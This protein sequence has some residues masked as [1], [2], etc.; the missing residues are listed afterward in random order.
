VQGAY[1]LLCSFIL[2]VVTEIKDSL[3]APPSDVPASPT[4]PAKQRVQ[5]QASEAP[6]YPVKQNVDPKE[7]EAAWKKATDEHAI[8][9]YSKNRRAFTEH[10]K[11]FPRNLRRYYRVLYRS[12]GA[13]KELVY[14]VIA[15][16][17]LREWHHLR[18]Q[19]YLAFG[20]HRKK[21]AFTGHFIMMPLIVFSQMLLLNHMIG[22]FF[23]PESL[24]YGMFGIR[25]GFFYAAFLVFYSYRK[26]GHNAQV[27]YLAG[28]MALP[29]GYLWILS[30]IIYMDFPSFWLPIGLGLTFALMTT[31]SHKDEDKLP[32]RMTRFLDWLT[33]K[34][35]FARYEMDPFKPWRLL[36]EAWISGWISEYVAGPRLF[37][38][39]YLWLLD[40]YGLDIPVIKEAQ[41]V[42]NDS[43]STKNMGMEYPGGGGARPPLFWKPPKSYKKAFEEIADWEEYSKE[44]D[45]QALDADE[46]KRVNYL[47]SLCKIYEVATTRRKNPLTLSR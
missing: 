3:S 33:M 10:K 37:P 28:I 35:F 29:I 22:F 23:L 47:R 2:A 25:G 44:N 1:T 12:K 40:K 46:A 4:V 39:F 18:Y 24:S 14:F 42:A 32:P 9:R 26:M 5:T 41:R 13:E 8:P 30:N 43:V 38:I 36:I 6:C 21:L 7:D 16:L 15:P 11:Y 45:H 20:F 17:S 19:S 31:A 34:E 27:K